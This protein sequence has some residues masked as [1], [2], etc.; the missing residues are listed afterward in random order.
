MKKTIILLLL[1]A[2]GMA[3]NVAAAAAFGF[4]FEWGGI[5]TCTSGNPNTVNSPVFNLSAVPKEAAKIVFH[6][7]DRNV[8]EFDHGGGT[9]AYAGNAVIN[10][11]TFK[12]K[13]PCPPDGSHIYVWTAVVYDKGG[14]KLV[15]A[16]SGKKYP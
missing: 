4:T 9:A 8:P 2:V 10:S 3:M 16:S 13:S 6:L 7:K 5:P 15:A 1:A 14:K 11:G 12:Y